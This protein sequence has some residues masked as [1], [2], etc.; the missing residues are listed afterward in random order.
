M[1]AHQITRRLF[2]GICAGA[3]VSGL[4][5]PAHAKGA[6]LTWEAQPPAGGGAGRRYRA[7]AQV[8]L[9]SIPLLRRSGVGDGSVT[10][11]EWS[12]ANG[13]PL[14]L[15][16]FM[17]RS[18]PE[19]AAGLNRFGFIRELSGAGGESI[20]F[21]LMS[22]S[23]E[24]SAAEARKALHSTAAEAAYS[25]IEGR[26]GP[27]ES[28]TTG[29]HFTAPSNLSSTAQDELI[30]RARQTLSGVPKRTA[31][32]DAAA[33]PHLPF[34]HA[35]AELVEHPD[36][37]ETRYIYDGSQYLLRVKRSADPSAAKRFKELRLLGPTAKVVRI[38]GR[39]QREAGGKEYDFRLWFEE[40]AKRPLPLRIEY[41][42][43][44]YLRLMFEA[45]G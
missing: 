5:R 42:P 3:V 1:L 4:S 12:G 32:L 19:R 15:L 40:G 23:P 36:R 20:Y 44:S 37:S 17:G 28:E 26:V 25:V 24:E 22:A 30:K 7:D 16:E 41:Q 31:A 18:I 45:E 6:P 35:L 29:A 13:Q 2:G 38:A 8:L 10:W 43:K 9:F 27:A 11:R 39:L 33:A 14:K 21:G 34:L